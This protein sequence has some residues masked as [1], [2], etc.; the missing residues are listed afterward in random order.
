MV[1]TLL[2]KKHGDQRKVRKRR[3]IALMDQ[4]LKLVLK[5]VK[6]LT[7]DRM[8]GRT[9]IDNKGW[10]PGHGALNA[11]LIAACM[12]GQTQ[13][14]QQMTIIIWLDL[15][16]FFPSIKRRPRRLAEWLLGLPE[17]V[18]LLAE[19]VFR[20]MMA[21]IDTAHGLG[22]EYEILGGDLMGCVLS[23]SHARSLL[24]IISEAIA[25]VSAGIQLWGCRHEA[26]KIAQTMMAD[27]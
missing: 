1:F 23:P 17:D 12:L 26:R 25:A 19:E 11:A 7:F 4:T 9:G 5:C 6:R 16:Q 3:E 21:R 24:T 18:A 2:R 22:D 15:A 27:D 8:V 14:L 13:E 20:G 10:I